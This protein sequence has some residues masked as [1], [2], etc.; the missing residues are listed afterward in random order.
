MKKT[1]VES[2]RVAALLAKVVE[3]TGD[4]ESAVLEH[5]LAKY[6][7]HLAIK[8]NAEHSLNW[9]EDKDWIPVPFRPKR[10]DSDDATPST[11]PG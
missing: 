11:T 3:I 6:Y 8:H 7:E 5:A 1:T 2:D 4:S 10:T 9:L